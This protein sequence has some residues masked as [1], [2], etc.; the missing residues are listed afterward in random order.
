MRYAGP[1]LGRWKSSSEIE[2][3][4]AKLQIFSSL[5]AQ[6]LAELAELCLRKHY[7][8]GD[9]IV[10]QG[11]TGLGLF[12]LV[13]GRVEVFKARDGHRLRLAELA[14]GDV[15]GEIALLDHQPRSASA[16][17]LEATECLLMTRDRFRSLLERRPRIAW[18]LV[19]GLALRIRGLQDQLL[20]ADELAA[21]RSERKLAANDA[22]SRGSRTD[23]QPTT[24]MKPTHGAPAYEAPAHDE[25]EH[26]PTEHSDGSTPSLLQVQT[27]LLM[28]GAAGIVESARLF[29]V[30]LRAFEANAGFL[31]NRPL[32]STARDLPTSFL[33]ASMSTW[34]AGSR[35]PGKM[36]N[37]LQRKL[38]SA[39]KADA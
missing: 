19:P 33:G 29:D 9:E 16:V 11:S 23:P 2:D 17:A 30:F 32:I 4:L 36:L 26:E 10:E 18:A 38:H 5:S 21:R 14:A 15:L 13:S 3:T 20:T 37:V 22:Q 35:I 27:A 25:V 12:V 34:R 28:S 1:M 39:P 6:D 31:R 8:E 7:A 24:K